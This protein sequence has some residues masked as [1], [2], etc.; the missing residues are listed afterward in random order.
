MTA[1]QQQLTAEALQ[2]R[3]AKVLE[4]LRAALFGRVARTG[5]FTFYTYDGWIDGYA[6]CHPG[7]GGSEG[8]RRLRE[9]RE[10]GWK[11]DRR[12]HPIYGRTTQQYRLDVSHK[13]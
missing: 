5:E 3:Q 8:L 1:I 6:L 9:L 12:K 4:A 7:I 13:P 11:I 2:P 10:K